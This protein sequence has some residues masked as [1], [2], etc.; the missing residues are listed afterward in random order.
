[1]VASIMAG[2]SGYLLKQ[3]RPRRLIEAVEQVAA[4]GSLLDPAV[5][6]LVLDQVCG[7]GTSRSADPQARLSDQEQRIV[8]SVAE[9]K[10]NRQIAAELSLSDRT[11]KFHVSN[12]LQKLQLS[13]RSEAAVFAVRRSSDNLPS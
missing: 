12:I 8:S 6:R 10:T 5:T 9:G 1:M 11:V 7:L 4:G 3:I 2:A 13:R